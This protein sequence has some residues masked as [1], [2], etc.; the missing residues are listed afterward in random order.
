MKPTMETSDTIIDPHSEVEKLQ[1]LVKTLQRQNE[2]LRS[3]QKNAGGDHQQNGQM[4]K[5]VSNHN[6]NISAKPK[7]RQDSG[8]EKAL[9]ET[10][11]DINIINLDD[12]SLKD[13]EDSWLYSSP[14][15]PTP[16]QTRVSPYKWVRQEFDNPSLKFQ[17]SKRSL[18]NKLEEVAR[19][20]RSSSTPSLGSCASESRSLSSLNRSVGNSQNGHHRPAPRQFL[21]ASNQ[22]GRIDTGTFTRPKRTKERQ[23]QNSFEK[24]NEPKEE[25]IYK[26]PDVY[27]IENLAKLQEESLR[28]SISPYTSPRKGLRSRQLSDPD[29]IGS[30]SGSNRSSPGRFDGDAGFM[31]YQQHRNSIGSD[32]SSPPESPHASQYLSP[33]LPMFTPESQSRRSMQASNILQYSQSTLHSSDSSLDHQSNCSDEMNLAPEGRNMNRLHQP[34]IRAQSPGYSGLKPPS[35]GLRGAS[36]SRSSLPTPNRRT[37]PRPSAGRSSLPT[38]KRSNMSSPRPPS[39]QGSEESWREGCF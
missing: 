5:V 9:V 20:N 35:A 15:A 3:K 16:Q 8:Q 39:S 4:D 14:K 10:A 22:G 34:M 17:S 23:K 12:M 13:E 37:I 38:P 30:P 32:A 26:S 33:G 19:I 2:A 28:Q 21:M 31:H 27:E 1:E 6:N 29:N 18:I 36:P 24:E 11:D 25:A 7:I